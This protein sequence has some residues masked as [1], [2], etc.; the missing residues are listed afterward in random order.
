MGKDSNTI[1]SI[2]HLFKTVPIQVAQHTLHHPFIRVDAH[3][4]GMSNTAIFLLLI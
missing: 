4:A 2:Q 3:G 1:A